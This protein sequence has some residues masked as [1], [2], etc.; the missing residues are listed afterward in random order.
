MKIAL[1]YNL[2]SG[3]AKR[4]VYEWTRRLVRVHQIDVYTLLTADHTFC[5]LRPFVRDYRV[6][7]FTPRKLFKSPLGRLNQWQRQN[8]LRD[9]RSLG[10]NIVKDM[11]RIGYDVVF[12]HPCINTFIPSF[13]PLLKIPSVYYLHE[14]FGR[15]FVRN[16]ERPYFRQNKFRETIDKFDPIIHLYNQ[17]LD[18][19]QFESVMS[20]TRLLANSYF[21]REHMLANFNVEAPVCY[22]GVDLQTF[23]PLENIPRGDHIISVGELTPRKG[24]DFL[25]KSL[26]LIPSSKR[27]AFKLVCNSYEQDEMDYIKSLAEQLG[28]KLHILISLNA[29]E[30][31]IEYNQAKACIYAPVL[32]PFGLVPVEAM[33]CGTPVI[34]VREGGFQEAITHNQTGILVDRD[35]VVFSD[36]IQSV[37]SDTKLSA[38]L[39][40]NSRLNVLNNWSWERSVAS[41][42]EHLSACAGITV[43]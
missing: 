37:I 27:P 24:F 6:Y 11:H 21:T 34:G 10:K 39:G 15:K 14:P 7:D 31:A 30:L 9:L 18:R 22:L 12:A 32:E 19:I 40:H 1:F 36:A 38:E 20:T 2:P 5:D 41:I 13:I 28:V 29:E 43:N 17:R 16:V 42:E 26:S 4:A 8:D 23:Q 33:A 3:G 25:I 35:P